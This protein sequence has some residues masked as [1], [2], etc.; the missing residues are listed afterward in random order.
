MVG[1]RSGHI[2]AVYLTPR[3]N[4][5]SIVA[6]TVTTRGPNGPV[7]VDSSPSTRGGIVY[8]GIGWAGERGVGGYEAINPNG[9]RRWFHLAVNPS[10]DPT[11]DA[12]V[13]AG[14]TVGVLQSQIAVVGPSLGQRTYV[15]NASSGALLR[16]FPWF[17]ADTEY[18][19][20][21]LADVEGNGQ[22]QI[23][24]GG[25]TTAGISYGTSY[26]D[27]GEIRILREGGR[28]QNLRHPGSGLYCQYRTDQGVDSSPAVGD[29]FGG[30]PGIVVGTSAERAGK[31]TTDD[32]IAI[33]PSCRLMWETRLDGVTVSSPALADVLDN[34][35]LQVV[36]GT[37]G[38]SVYCLDAANGAVYWK[39]KV[40]GSVIGGVVTADLG[41]G[42]QDLVVPT[43]S[44]A[45]ILDGRT[46][47]VLATL[48][49]DVGLQNSPLVTD[50]PNGTVGITVA[51]YSGAG[52][53]QHAV[54]EHFE[55]VGSS[56]ADVNAVGTWPEFHH[57]PGLS[58][59][60]SLPV[61]APAPHTVAG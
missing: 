3:A 7:G 58:G 38:G 54:I 8:F 56:G 14:L 22:N 30:R 4:G 27:G 45:F 61:A 12:G 18:S 5:R 36:E 35:S 50:D 15:L 9:S 40:K 44:G 17:Q 51:G 55:I 6:W 41:Q 42:R 48:E 21:A 11:R 37:E 1:D 49:N 47:V 53:Y 16:G 33:N 32:V 25:N 34:G 10:T 46:G 20:A 39:T 24:E 43:T 60:A 19:T 57:D 29:I 23:I 13:A 28:G 26:S 31:K 52:G 59:N 2:F